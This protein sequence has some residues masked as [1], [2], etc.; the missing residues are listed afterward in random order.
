MIPEVIQDGLNGFISN[1][2]KELREKT[3]MLLD[4]EELRKTMGEN[5]R[6]TIQNMFSEQRFLDEWNNTFDQIC[7]AK[8]I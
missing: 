8:K 3:E 1:D 2:E 6:K 7:E 5:A 4:N